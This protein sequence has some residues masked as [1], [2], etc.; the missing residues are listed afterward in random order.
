MNVHGALSFHR[1]P[2]SFTTYT[3]RSFPL[4]ASSL[5]WPWAR[6]IAPYWSDV[7]ITVQPGSITYR[8]LYPSNSS[9]LLS[10]ISQMSGL[11]NFRANWGLIVTWNRV[12]YYQEHNDKVMLF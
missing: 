12:G 11:K 4:N 7:D 2:I 10:C 9:G 3:P 5:M 6:M 1:E 8:I